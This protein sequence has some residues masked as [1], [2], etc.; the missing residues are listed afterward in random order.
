MRTDDLDSLE[1]DYWTARALAR[2]DLP[3]AFVALEPALVVTFSNGTAARMDARFAPSSRWA[4]A[5]G[6][7]DRLIDVR[8]T[9]D[10]HGTLSCVATFDADGTCAAREAHGSGPD[11]RTALLRAFVRARFGDE[12]EAMPGEPHVVRHGKLTR[13]AQGEPIPSHGPRDAEPE[14]NT[15]GSLPRQ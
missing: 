5:T 8:S 7:L 15:I 6:V 3:I 2:D 12:V 4:D 11:L 13:H 14:P 9:R 1:L 10:A